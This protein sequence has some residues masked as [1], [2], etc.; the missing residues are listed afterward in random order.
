MAIV[1]QKVGEFSVLRLKP[2][3]YQKRWQASSKNPQAL[4]PIY[5][6]VD[7]GQQSIVL[8]QSS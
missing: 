5:G 6:F 8:V 2:Q 1:Q 7:Y 3:D 4:L